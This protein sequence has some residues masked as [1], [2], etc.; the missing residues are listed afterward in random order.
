MKLRETTRV[1]ILAKDFRH[2]SHTLRSEQCHEL[3]HLYFYRPNN[4]PQS[5]AI[6]RRMHRNGHRVAALAGQADVTTLLSHLPVA[7]FVERTYAVTS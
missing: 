5:T 3:V 1:R 7:K 4:C 6:K 2:A